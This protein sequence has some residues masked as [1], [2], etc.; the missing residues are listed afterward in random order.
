MFG[1]RVVCVVCVLCGFVCYLVFYVCSLW[2]MGVRGFCYNCG[3]CIFCGEIWV[4]FV[5]CV[6]FVRVVFVG[7]L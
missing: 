3:V 6:Y 4:V 1:V 7:F 2:F 5:C